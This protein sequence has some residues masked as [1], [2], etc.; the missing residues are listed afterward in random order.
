[1][2]CSETCRTKAASFHINLEHNELWY[3]AKMVPDALRIAGG[4]S[5]LPEL[6]KD[7]DDKTIFDF[8]FSDP[9]D[10]S[11]ERSL[12]IAVNGLC[13][14]DNASMFTELQL[15]DLNIPAI[16]EQ[17]ITADEREQL[18]YCLDNQLKCLKSNFAAIQ[19]SFG[20]FPLHALIN[21]SCIPNVFS[22]FCGEKAFLFVARPLKVG[23]QIFRTYRALSVNE[24]TSVPL[25]VLR[26]YL[27]FKCA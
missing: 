5:E 25:R 27:P 4:V 10:P 11:Y 13:K 12:L 23:E 2:F 18:M 3:F 21:H 26:H 6:L 7:S 8:D 16:N 24:K 1:M 15:Q 17:L 20:V 14:N 22:I 19:E 9:D